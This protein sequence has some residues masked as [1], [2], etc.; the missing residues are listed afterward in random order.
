[1]SLRTKLM[2]ANGLMA[3]GVLPL[4]FFVVWA[5]GIVNWMRGGSAFV[6]I[7]DPIGMIGPSIAGFLFT[8]TV[9][10]TAAAWSWDL[11]RAHPR[12]R[13]RTALAFR[14]MTAVVLISPF[15]LLKL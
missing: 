11:V 13:S 2:I 5:A 7:M 6:P 10:G 9:A 8:F 3:I 1:M 12:Y 14:L 4:A 15:V